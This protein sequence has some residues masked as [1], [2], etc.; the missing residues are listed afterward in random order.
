MDE[1]KS[2]APAE[3]D[4]PESPTGQPVRCGAGDVTGCTVPSPG[5]PLD[6][7]MTRGASRSDLVESEEAKNQRKTSA[8]S[9]ALSGTTAP[10]RV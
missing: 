2:S 9:R 5:D 4:H 7:L 1:R 6:T 8:Q 10:S 3:T